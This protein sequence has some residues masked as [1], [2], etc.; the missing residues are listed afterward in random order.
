MKKPFET[1]VGALILEIQK[2][3]DG[4]QLL[5]KDCMF[6]LHRDTRFSNDKTPY[7]THMAAIFVPGGKKS[8]AEMEVPG[9]YFHISFGELAIGGGA[10][11]LDKEPL[12][13]V[14]RAIAQDP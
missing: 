11:A 12:M 5:P 13:R 4:F 7:K 8:M 1:L 6:R 10:Y 3:E 9:Y 14:R 2:F